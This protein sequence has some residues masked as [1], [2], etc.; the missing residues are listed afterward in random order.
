M[1]RLME[2]QTLQFGISARSSE[3]KADMDKLRKKVPTRVLAH[4]DRFALRGKKGVAVARNGVCSECHLRI[5]SGKL[6]SLV[7]TNDVQLWDNCGRYLYLPEDEPLGLN[8]PKPAPPATVKR[9]SQRAAHY[10]A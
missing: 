1:E 9:P 4:Y 2:L 8:D 5:I 10:V 6:V 7:Y 3:S